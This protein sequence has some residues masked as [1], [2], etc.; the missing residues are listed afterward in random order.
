[1]IKKILLYSAIGLFLLSIQ[2]ILGQWLSIQKIKPD[3]LLILVLYIGQREGKNFGQ[4]SGFVIGLLADLIGMSTFLG[5]SIFT[6][7]ISGFL[8]GCLKN[9]KLKINIFSYYAF[10]FV[11]MFIHNFLFFKIYYHS[12]NLSF[13]YMFVRYI[14]PSILYTSVFYFL[15]EFIFARHFQQR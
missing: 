12:M 5:L 6:K 7:V 2:G 4:L 8:A 11:V 3:F 15:F 10:I 14:L 13:Q 9:Q 1:M